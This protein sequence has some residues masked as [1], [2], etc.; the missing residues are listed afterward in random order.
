GWSLIHFLWQGVLIAGA[1]RIIRG[2]TRPE[3]AR[4]RYALSCA[5][6]AA[7]VVAPAVTALTNR[8][9]SPTPVAKL[10]PHVFVARSVAGPEA[11]SIPF[12]LLPSTSRAD[13]PDDAMT[14]LVI[15]WLTGSIALSIRLIGGCL[16][17]ARMKSLRTDVPP[18]EWRRVLEILL[19][20]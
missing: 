2:A 3:N 9:P 8:L 1:Y 6:M 12:G 10:L 18:P 14:W 20:R 17:A 11:G 4:T 19:A 7:M 15:I 13:D 5:A 16:V